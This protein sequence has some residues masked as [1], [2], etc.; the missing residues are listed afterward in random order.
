MVELHREET[1]TSDCVK[2][3]LLLAFLHVLVGSDQP[4]EADDVVA[5][6]HIVDEFVAAPA[7]LHLG[8]D[9]FWLDV[10]LFGQEFQRLDVLVLGHVH[11]D[12]SDWLVLLNLGRDVVLVVAADRLEEGRGDTVLEDELKKREA[13]A[14]FLPADLFENEVAWGDFVCHAE[15]NHV[16]MSGPVESKALE[17]VSCLC[18][19]VWV[20]KVAEKLRLMERS[21][22]KVDFFCENSATSFLFSL[23]LVFT[24][25][26]LGWIH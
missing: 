12:V 16:L 19:L 14:V 8:K 2:V 20:V 26:N 23:L 21:V 22:N 3:V 25:L 13:A 5:L 17:W 11:P 4:I 18:V 1:K 10:F 6:W 9:V 24:E 7:C 15:I